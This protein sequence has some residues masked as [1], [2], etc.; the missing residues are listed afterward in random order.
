VECLVWDQDAAGSSPVTST[1]AVEQFARRLII[2]ILFILYILINSTFSIAVSK[3][4]K[5]GLEVSLSLTTA[6]NNIFTIF[7]ITGALGMVPT[8]NT[9]GRC[10]TE[11]W[12]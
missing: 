6:L 5:N 3:K 4:L 10:K 12:S 8:G 2:E 7:G 9:C 1:K 11:C